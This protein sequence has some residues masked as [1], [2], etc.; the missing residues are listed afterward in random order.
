MIFMAQLWNKIKSWQ[1]DYFILATIVGNGI[2]LGLDLLW[3]FFIHNRHHSVWC[4][5]PFLIGI[6]LLAGASL[7]IVIK[8]YRE[9]DEGVWLFVSWLFSVPTCGLI[10]IGIA[11]VCSQM[12]ASLGLTAFGYRNTVGHQKWGET[13]FPSDT[14][15]L[16]SE[17]SRGAEYDTSEIRETS[18]NFAPQRAHTASP[19]ER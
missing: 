13:I 1:A 16:R 6:G 19:A 14:A 8:K 12:A 4:I 2:I 18:A 10:V 3:H 15:P 7:M 17:S 11:M 9:T 5:A